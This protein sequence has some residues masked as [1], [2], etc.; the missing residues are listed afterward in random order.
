MIVVA[1]SG[2]TKTDWRFIHGIDKEVESLKTRGFNPYFHTTNFIYNELEPQ[3]R[4][5]NIDISQVKEVY[6]YGAGCS[7]GDKQKI[8]Q[9]ALSKIFENA[10][11]NI[12]HDLLGAARA[13][14]GPHKGIACILG[15]GSNSCL[16]DGEKIIDNIPSHGFIFGD[17]GS[18]SFLGKE[19]I[20]LY[21]NNQLP[22]NLRRDLLNEFDISEEIVLRKVYREENP[23]VYLASFAT[24]YTTHKDAELL[25]NIMKKGFKLFFERRV[26]PYIGATELQVNFVGSI[27]YY[28]L[29]LLK[30]VASTYGVEVGL[31]DKCPV[32]K[33]IQYH[34]SLILN[35][36]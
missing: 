22:D 36:Y 15:T 17:E 26:I 9:D 27:A 7:S 3:F 19:L 8:V 6:Y 29:P 1:D 16:W 14:L 28:F 31:V 32:N 30:E 12:S 13:T 25:N 21:L 35:N 10:I 34:S 2:S 33:L 23:N 11:I 5:S 20:Q 4:S 18:G 24:F